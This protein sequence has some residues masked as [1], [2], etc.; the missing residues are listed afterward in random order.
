[1][2]DIIKKSNLYRRLEWSPLHRMYISFNNPAYDAAQSAEMEFY[3][4]FIKPGALVF[5]VG[6]NYGSKS[7][8]F[9][10]L[11]ARVIAVE[12]DRRSCQILRHRFP[13]QRRFHLVAKALG[14]SVGRLELFVDQPGSAYNTFSSKWRDLAH[15][16]NTARVHVDVTTVDALVSK[17]GIPA[18]LKIDVEGFEREVLH[19]MKFAVPI[20]SFEANLP[21]FCEETLDCIDRLAALSADYHFHVCRVSFGRVARGKLDVFIG[22]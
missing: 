5:D 11:G 1:M 13:F 20:L 3:R 12:P 4:Q 17:Y 15:R 10:R 16:G 18:F 2:R 8:V 9:L 7:E 19:G 6:A 21:A 14:E 22:S